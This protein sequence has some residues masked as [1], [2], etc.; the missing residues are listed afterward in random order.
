MNKK[1]YVAPSARVLTLDSEDML[2]TSILN[3]AEDDLSVILSDDEYNG[4]FSSRR[5]VWDED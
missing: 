3:A 1:Y 2:A 5:N 4:E